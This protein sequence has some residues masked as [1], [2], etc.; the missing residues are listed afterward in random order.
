MPWKEVSI[1]FS[2]PLPSGVRKSDLKAALW[3]PDEAESIKYRPEYA[4]T[5][6]EGVTPVILGGRLLNV[7]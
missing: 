2:A 4:I 3:L 5:I 6:A 1:H 7:M